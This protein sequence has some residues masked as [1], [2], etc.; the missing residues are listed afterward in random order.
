[1]PHERH[2][3]HTGANALP[4][5]AGGAEWS[6]ALLHAFHGFLERVCDEPEDAAYLMQKTALDLNDLQ[7]SMHSATC[8]SVSHGR[9][10]ASLRPR[11]KSKLARVDVVAASVWEAFRRSFQARGSRRPEG[12]GY[13]ASAYNDHVKR[14]DIS[15][16]WAL[17]CNDEDCSSLRSQLLLCFHA[18]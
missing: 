4:E 18:L 2:R 8:C 9:D 13:R 15:Q 10:I 3:I 14:F 7:R 6:A 1:E 5:K 16:V 12:D 11:E 17:R